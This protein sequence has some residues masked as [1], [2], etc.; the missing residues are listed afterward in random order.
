MTTFFQQHRGAATPVWLPTATE[1]LGLRRAQIGA[2]WALAAHF[3][4]SE[5]PGQVVLPT[6]VGK[7]AVMT[8]SAMLVPCTRILAIA[9]SHV[10]RDQIG[11]EFESMTVLRG[12]DSIPQSL[13][14]PKVAIADHRLAKE[15]DWRNLSKFDVV[16]GTPG[17]L[18]PA[19]EGVSDPPLGL[20]DFVIV[21][22]GHHA[23]ATTWQAA[24]AAF[25]AARIALFTATPFRRDRKALPGTLAYDYPLA[26]AISDGVYATV[27]YQQVDVAAGADRDVA[28]AHKVAERLSD[29][30]HVAASSAFIARTDRLEH[31]RSLVGVYQA[32][33]LV[34][35]MVSG[36]DSRKRVRDTLTALGDGSIAGVITVGV[37]GEGLDQ[38][39]LKIAAYHRAHKSLAPTL[40]FVGRISRISREVE[41]P[42]E[43]IAIP[44][45][46]R[47]ETS[48]LYEE[49]A[50]WADL[51]PDLMDSAVEAERARTQYVSELAQPR[52][53]EFSMYA[54]QPIKETQV[55]TFDESVTPDLSV[56]MK[57]LGNGEV[58]HSA[59]DDDGSLLVLVSAHRR[60]PE[61]MRTDALDSVEYLLHLAVVDMTRRLLFISAGSESALRTIVEAVGASTASLV[62]GRFLN[63]ILHSEGVESYFSVGMRSTTPPGGRRAAYTTLSG[64]RVGGAVSNTAA[65]THGLGHM[66]ARTRDDQGRFSAL[67]VSV[68]RAKVWVPDTANLYEYRQWCFSLAAKIRDGVD[69]GLTAPGLPLTLPTTFDAFPH[70]PFAVLHD[71]ALVESGVR[72]ITA[73]GQECPAWEAE[74]EV[75]RIDD[76]TCYLVVSVDDSTLWEGTTSTQGRV[77][78][79]TEAVTVQPGASSTRTFSEVLQGAPPSIYFANGAV[80]TGSLMWTTGDF[81]ALDSA[82]LQAWD[83]AKVDTHSES[84]QP[85]KGMENI[86]DRTARW[87]REKWPS[88]VII[89]EDGKGEIADLVVV[90]ARSMER[91]VSLFHCKW[92][93]ASAPRNNLDDLYEVVG[94][95][96]RSTAW[97]TLPGVFLSRLLERLATRSKTAIHRN[98]PRG[99]EHLEALA[100][101][102]SVTKFSIYIVQPGLRIQTVPSW[103]EG[104]ILL[105]ACEEWCRTED[106]PL[107]IVGA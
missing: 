91:D 92:T 59:T 35:R 26:S 77:E 17:C 25:S 61:W 87:I 107:T 79:L 5:Q 94:Q 88:A 23:P 86:L 50:S 58:V 95:A 76:Q 98:S 27:S 44:D 2:A 93:S 51:V 4:R 10:V 83:W 62:S 96:M 43:L 7:T 38:P 106:V 32:E 57:R 45:D 54:L 78:A 28:I 21:D 42:A 20:F 34:A 49:D 31:A 16:V 65:R 103:S 89:T 60:H 46:V 53:E 100:A 73:E 80:V 47:D 13:P 55:F 82:I 14:K 48:R 24:L 85:A 66:I 37:L 33:G 75:E 74:I 18:S 12:T 69:R 102:R 11:G 6:G 70:N 39:R 101:T 67:G 19:F 90:N 22:E 81:P 64:S 36:Q 29:S 71:R 105:G 56:E 97:T 9:P 1:V 15:S 72:I 68:N 3:T 30:A 52:N 40:Q 41:A 104:T 8:L 63:R 84:R 99:K